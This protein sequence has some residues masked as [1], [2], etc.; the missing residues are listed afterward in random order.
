MTVDPTL[1]VES[2]LWDA[3]PLVIGMDEVGRGA[4]AGPV[5]VGAFALTR[6]DVIPAGLR[7]S[8]VMTSHRVS[9]IGRAHV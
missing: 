7:D 4:L 6:C 2:A 9:E 8:K 1:E 5:S 3:R